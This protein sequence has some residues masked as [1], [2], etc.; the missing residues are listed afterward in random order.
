[1]IILKNIHEKIIEIAL[2]RC[3]DPKKIE[4]FLYPEKTN[5]M[6]PFD[7]PGVEEAV[8]RIKKGI[9]NKERILI[10]GD[11]DAD[12]IT[13]T[14]LLYR[15]LCKIHN[16]VNYYIPERDGEGYGLNK[17]ALTQIS[18]EGTNLIITVDCGIKSYSLVKEFS[19]KGLDFIITDHHTPDDLIPESIVVNPKLQKESD[20]FDLAGVGVAY[21]IF[22]GLG[23]FYP[24]I[25]DLDSQLLQL[26]AIGTVA[27]L[28]NLSKENRKIVRKGIIHLNRN[29]LK[30]IKYIA[31]K[32]N[33]FEIN[34]KTIS[35]LLAP[36]INS[37]GRMGSP[38]TALKLLISENDRELNLLAD[39]L[40]NLN[41][42]RKGL[43]EKVYKEA[44]KIILE[45]H[46]FSD[47]F[48]LAAKKDWP[49]GI[50]GIVASRLM[51]E[52]N[53]PVL[54][55]S[56]SEEGIYK[57]S[58]RS[59]EKYNIFNAL[60]QFENL[61]EE[62]GGHAQAAGLSI[63][64]K[65]INILRNNLNKD[66]YEKLKH[67]DFYNDFYPDA[68]LNGIEEVSDSLYEDLALL[69]PFGA[70]N[71]EPLFTFSNNV[72]LKVSK[73][74]KLKDHLRVDISKGKMKMKG[75]YFNFNEYPGDEA[76][77][78]L[79]FALGINEWQNK[80]NLQLEIKKIL[81]GERIHY[82]KMEET[83]YSNLYF[84]REKE[85]KSFTTGERI[86]Y[87]EIWNILKKYKGILHSKSIKSNF[88]NAGE[89]LST[90]IFS[91]D[92]DQDFTENFK[93][94][95]RFIEAE[96]KGVLLTNSLLLKDE[97][98]TNTESYIFGDGEPDRGLI[99]FLTELHPQIK[100]F[101][102][103]E[104]LNNLN[105]NRESLSRLF[106]LI[107]KIF[108]KSEC[109]FLYELENIF[110]K[111]NET[112]LTTEEIFTGIMIFEELGFLN[113]SYKNSLLEIKL[114]NIAGKNNLENSKLY[115]ISNLRI[116]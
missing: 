37:S 55:L 28:V 62:F 103:D 113:Y 50:L 110:N 18:L 85:A 106:L 72:K 16:Q 32:N 9:E 56:E 89:V 53:R 48:I 10:Y 101:F 19:E 104:G 12:G 79:I 57:G 29:P 107:K 13:S 7:L 81:D 88:S 25:L 75:I 93:N 71:P 4:D 73:I 87:N 15:A 42:K 99:N 22:R 54:L 52:Y 47:P 59:I 108:S 97:I 63:L 64:E 8:L 43:V 92:N 17:E 46:Y 60:K 5:L 76:E 26:A 1:M 34:S 102:L 74:G 21:T 38:E 109:I 68:E 6:A 20:F 96:E 27:D 61:I 40:I 77:S 23:E 82:Q 91:Y 44:Q 111:D 11:Y 83:I 86:K 115:N 70:G 31:E 24:E 65:N 3:P 112:E 49:L 69:E 67:E 98:I 95:K 51:N 84:P 58:A 2:K 35:F 90:Q 33:V 100:I 14:A 30:G 45:N 41:N 36:I 78:N 94:I 39:E 114:N 66:I 80:V 105:I 116:R